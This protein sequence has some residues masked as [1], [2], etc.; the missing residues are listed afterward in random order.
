MTLHGVDIS[1]WQAGFDVKKCAGQFMIAKATEGTTF[2]DKNCDGFVQQ[3]KAAGIPWGVYHFAHD[4][5]DDEVD[6]FVKQVKGYVKGGI[7]VLDWEADAV[8]KGV[9]AA[10]NFLDG[11]YS[12]TGVR[13]LI[14][15]SASVVTGSNWSSVYNADYGLWVAAYQSNAP[16]APWG[17]A[18]YAMWQHTSSY[19]TPCGGVDGNYFYGDAKTWA[20][21]AGSSGTTPPKP[22]PP[23]APKFPYPSTDYLGTTRSDPHCHSGYYTK[24]QPNIRT[25][26]QQMKNR[27]WTIGVDGLYGSQS[28]SVCRQFQSEKGLSADGLVGPDTWAKSWTAP[29]T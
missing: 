18:G 2:V 8:S 13:P 17:S 3:A 19:S 22:K 4:G 24:D 20:A 5:G 27:G 28:E 6:F 11:V 7:L 14:Y 23:T 21:Y 29:V 25:W 9:S 10:K 26:Q 1:N 15:M 12:E 16:T